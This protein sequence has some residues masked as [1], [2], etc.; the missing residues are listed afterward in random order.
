MFKK[1][2]D[3]QEALINPRLKLYYFKERYILAFLWG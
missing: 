2:L 1:H 3:K